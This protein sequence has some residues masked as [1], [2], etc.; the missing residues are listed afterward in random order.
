MH[1][2]RL[3]SKENCAYTMIIICRLSWVFS[4]I[5]SVEWLCGVLWSVNWDKPFRKQ[6]SWLWQG[7]GNFPA[8]ENQPIFTSSSPPVNDHSGK[9]KFS[10]T[11]LVLVAFWFVNTNLCWLRNVEELRVWMWASEKECTIQW[12]DKFVILF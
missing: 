7:T 4:L 1:L 12:L 2:E 8:K 10:T 5:L 3:Y 11:P 9:W 6:N